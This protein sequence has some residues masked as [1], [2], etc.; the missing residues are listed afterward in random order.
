MNTLR[1]Q[2]PLER[3]TFI[4]FLFTER[5]PKDFG[6]LQEDRFP[7]ECSGYHVRSTRKVPS[8]KMG[9]NNL[10]FFTI[11][12]L[13]F[14]EEELNTTNALRPRGTKTVAKAVVDTKMKVLRIPGKSPPQPTVK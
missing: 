6:L 4:R 5:A 9:G 8:S 10:L 13:A 1:C 3:F 2:L 11:V 14:V 7:Y 12:Q